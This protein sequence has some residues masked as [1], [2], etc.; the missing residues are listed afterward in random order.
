MKKVIW[1][2]AIL[3]VVVGVTAWLNRGGQE[4]KKRSQDDATFAIIHGDRRIEIEFADVLA[5]PQYEFDAILRS[6]GK[7]PV[8]TRYKGVEMRDLVVASGFDL[9]SV[10]QVI[11]K[12]VD[13]YTIVLTGDE[14][15]AADNVYIVYERDGVDLGDRE[16]GGSGPYQLVIRLDQYGQRWNKYLWEIELQ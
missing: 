9:E 10:N 11:T 8:D 14:I 2:I 3:A 13:G 6:S 16:S 12:A 7:A 4:E 1:I 5:Q 15:R